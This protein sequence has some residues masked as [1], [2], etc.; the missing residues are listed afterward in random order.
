MQKGEKG[1][2]GGVKKEDER[3]GGVGM[4]GECQVEQA[5]PPPPFHPLPRAGVRPRGGENDER[6]LLCPFQHPGGAAAAASGGG[7]F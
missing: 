4:R 3:K 5:N 2:G 7:A 6:W 1:K